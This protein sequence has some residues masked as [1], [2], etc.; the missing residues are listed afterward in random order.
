MPSNNSVEVYESLANISA[1]N[2]SP[3]PYPAVMSSI[4]CSVYTIPLSCFFLGISSILTCISFYIFYFVIG[5]GVLAYEIA[6]VHG[7]PWAVGLMFAM[8]NIFWAIMGGIFGIDRW[9]MRVYVV[10]NACYSAQKNEVRDIYKDL[11]LNFL[12]IQFFSSCVA[13]GMMFIFRSTRR[14]LANEMRLEAL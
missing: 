2:P 10:S 9:T 7:L 11:K 1:V 6:T 8:M 12:S 14:D 13:L 5:F 4:L 3:S